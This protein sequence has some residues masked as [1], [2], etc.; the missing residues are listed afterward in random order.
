MNQEPKEDVASYYHA[1][2][3]IKLENNMSGKLVKLLLIPLMAFLDA[4]AFGT[5]LAVK[6]EFFKVFFIS[7]FN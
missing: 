7:R 2:P 1:I 4:V 5:F 3:L 6:F